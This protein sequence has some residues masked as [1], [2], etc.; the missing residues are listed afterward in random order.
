MNNLACKLFFSAVKFDFRSSQF[1][2]RLQRVLFYIKVFVS[3][4]LDFLLHDV[5]Q[6]EVDNNKQPTAIF[7]TDCQ[8][9]SQFSSSRMDED[10]L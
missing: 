10:F 1:Y 8:L 7:I 3:C 2:R 4:I 9:A 6:G 5:P